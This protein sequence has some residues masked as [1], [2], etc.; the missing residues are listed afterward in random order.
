MHPPARFAHQWAYNR[1]S[2]AWPT[3]SGV[4]R[5]IVRI[6][7]HD[8]RTG[9]PEGYGSGV[10]IGSKG[11]VLTNNHVIEDLDFG[12]AQGRFTVEI[13]GGS[14]AEGLAPAVPAELI[15]RNEEKDLAILRTEGPD[16]RGFIDVLSAP[17]LDER[18]IECPIRVL[19]YPVIDGNLLGGTLTVTRG[20]VSGFYEPDL[21]K[22]DAE[23]NHGHSGGAALDDFGQFIGVPSS[24]AVGQTGKIGLLISAN[25][26]RS[27]I[28]S[29]FAVAVPHDSVELS[30]LLEKPLHLPKGNLDRSSRLPRLLGKFAVVE[31]ILAARDYSSAIA[32]ERDGPCLQGRLGARAPVK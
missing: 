7:K 2:V 31:R 32:Q 3:Q 21:L 27:W 4:Y 29:L 23:I 13:P 17:L 12:T 20:I 26:V 6:T 8:A 24:M 1:S 30:D 15:V 11:L 9:R 10:V 18:V 16:P 19:G 5:S 28:N 14:M 25:R 22:T